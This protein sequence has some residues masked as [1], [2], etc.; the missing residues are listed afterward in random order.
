MNLSK[1]K[2]LAV[3]LAVAAASSAQFNVPMSARTAGLAGAPMS[4]ITDIYAYP[5]HVTGYANH[6]SATWDGG[7][8][9]TRSFGDALTLG[10]LANQ[11]L[12]APHFAD[13]AAARLNGF[14]PGAV[15]PA[16]F[17]TQINVPHL[18][19]G[20]DL[21]AARVGADIFF[22]YAGYRYRADSGTDELT[23]TASV[24]NPGA[25]LSAGF[26]AGDIGILVKFGIGFPS[27]NG[28]I[29]PDG[30]DKLS[31]E[32]GVYMEMGA[33]AGMPIGDVDWSI[34][35]DYTRAD[36][37]FRIGSTADPTSECNS[38]MNIYFGGE[39]N[40]VETAVAALRYTF[41]REARTL[42]QPDATG[43]PSNSAP[44]LHYH[45]FTAGL[46]NAWSKVWI[47]DAVQLRGGI[48][49]VVE[50]NGEKMSAGDASSGLSR[51]ETQNG[52]TPML[53][54]GVSKAFFTLDL[55]LDMGNWNGVFTGPGVALATATVKF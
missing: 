25:R 24:I 27:I 5:V 26:D 9:L 23:Y 34:G 16:N 52:L 7:V 1:I 53:G 36:H 21:G 19:V 8:I 28:E 40:F 45:V 42:T 13:A 22:E 38:L 18:L 29:P 17:N 51:P 6:I 46:E 32:A 33:E 35:A 15:P 48:R 10:I 37:R 31:S 14:I 20:F 30:S 55:A 12:M 44:I 2:A 54:I 4:D 49:H 39:F 47:F 41:A 3:V 43:D 50:V 11:G